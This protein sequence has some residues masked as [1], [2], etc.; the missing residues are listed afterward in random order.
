MGTKYVQRRTTA[1][2]GWAGLVALVG[3][4]CLWAGVESAAVVDVQ[5]M[6]QYDL[7]GEPL[8]SRKATFDLHASLMSSGS[9]LSRVVVV[10]PYLDLDVSAVQD[11]LDRK[12]SVSALLFVL[13]QDFATGA[14]N[15][16]AIE[17]LEQVLIH[18]KVPFP[19]YFAV[20]DENLETMIQDLRQRVAAGIAPSPTTGGYRLS[21]KAREGQ[22]LESTSLENHW[23]WLKGAESATGERN[24]TI[25]IVA[26]YDS[27]SVSPGL[28]VGSDSN[29][30]SI[31]SL[32]E[33]ARLFSRLYEDAKTK[34]NYN[35]LFLLTAGA[36]LG[37]NGAEH[38]LATVDARIFETVEFALCLDSL[39]T[40]GSDPEEGLHLH[41]SRPPKDPRIQALHA[42][43]T[44]VAKEL[45]IP[46]S[47]V[48]K[49]VDLSSEQVAWEHEQFSKKKIVAATL[50]SRAAPP[51]P[52]GF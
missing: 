43:F 32:L 45:D 6:I 41:I 31:A 52:L 46:F 51:P 7:G 26:Y 28:S 1:L 9:D 22:K 12:G 49:K 4:M 40:W 11:L 16:A 5:R 17:Q 24:P 39:G 21:T 35:I 42:E 8:G 47:I 19:V 18:R 36:A 37:Y 23:S 2:S 13:P 20:E 27:I 15:T 34:G 30:S 10:V 14:Y 50:S 25:A 44:A 48:Q 3:F 33:L 29:G 38:W